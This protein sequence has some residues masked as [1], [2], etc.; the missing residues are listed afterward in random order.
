MAKLAISKHICRKIA[1][2]FLPCGKEA[3]DKEFAKNMYTLYK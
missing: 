2:I 3:Q 1:F